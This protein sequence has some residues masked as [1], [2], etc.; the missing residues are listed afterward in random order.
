[1]LAYS[2]VDPSLR[3]KL[4]ELLKTWREP[5]P[6]SLQTAPVL[7]LQTTQSIVDALNRFRATTTPARPQQYP[8]QLQPQ[9]QA[10]A[11]GII[12]GGQP[13]RATP[14]PPQQHSYVQPAINIPRPAPAPT[15][16]PQYHQVSTKNEH[17]EFNTDTGGSCLNNR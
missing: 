5:V 16:Q 1:M 11:P 17:L 15:P 13:Y 10:H 2:Q 14:T 7:P 6:G 12:H 4:E 9:P 8:T 3:R